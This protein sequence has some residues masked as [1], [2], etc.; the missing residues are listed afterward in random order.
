MSKLQLVEQKIPQF[1]KYEVA[2]DGLRQEIRRHREHMDFQAAER[3]RQLKN[4]TDLAQAT[5][6]RMCEN[7][8]ML[9]KYAEHYQV[10][11]RA[12]AS[13]QDFQEQLQREQ[14]RFG[15]LQRLAEERQHAELEKFYADHE[16]R[17]QKQ[18]MELQPQLG[19]FQKSL[20]A[21]QHR[22]DE[23]VKLH[24]TLDD[25]MNIVLRII[26]ED[27]EAR[28]SAITNWQARLEALANGQA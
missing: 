4:W 25:Q 9:E 7:E 26:E 6:Q 21:M 17:W 24:Q 10:N 8:A 16:Q 14:H 3:E 5:E 13:L 23:L 20:E 1:A 19:D 2:L 27:V 22:L 28:A 15:E 11:K 12:L 18:T